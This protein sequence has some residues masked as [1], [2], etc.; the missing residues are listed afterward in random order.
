VLVSIHTLDKR[1]AAVRFPYDENLIDIV[2]DVPGR[3]WVPASKYWTIP[4]YEING[5]A[6]MFS[7]EGCTV[8]VDGEVWTPPV[9]VLP[10]PS[11]RVDLIAR[12]FESIPDYL[13]QPTHRALVRAWH[14]DTGGDKALAQ[15]L[16]QVW[17]NAP[18]G[19]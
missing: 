1:E 15:D 9:A 4:L 19:L 3:R 18:Q 8:T 14:P 11:N 2:R 10:V 5:C 17:S 6:A 12:L 16:N 7:E 13:V